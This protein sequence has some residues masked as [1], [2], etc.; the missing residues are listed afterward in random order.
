MTKTRSVFLG[1][2]AAGAAFAAVLAWAPALL[3]AGSLPQPAAHGP[4]GPAPLRLVVD[5]L[6]VWFEQQ[7]LEATLAALHPEASSRAYFALALA[8]NLAS[9]G[10]LCLELL[11]NA[12]D[13]IDPKDCTDEEFEKLH[14]GDARV[15]SRE[16]VSN[17]AVQEPALDAGFEGA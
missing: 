2:F 14:V 3:S 9:G 16:I 15:I 17:R 8:E 10:N 5:M 1:G 11:R 13:G 6:R 12:A 4:A 7:Q